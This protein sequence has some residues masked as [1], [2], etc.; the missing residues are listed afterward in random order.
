MKTN[1]IEKPECEIWSIRAWIHM[2]IDP[3]SIHKAFDAD[4]IRWNAIIQHEQ[5]ENRVIR[6]LPMQLCNWPGHSGWFI[7]IVGTLFVGT[8][9][10]ARRLSPTEIYERYD[11]RNVGK[12][13][14]WWRFRMIYLASCLRKMWFK[15]AHRIVKIIDNTSYVTK[16]FVSI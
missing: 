10:S 2:R 5:I 13:I 12:N 8:D 16:K 3:E 14:W 1:E 4:K 7:A 11:Y 6:Y 15:S 9:L